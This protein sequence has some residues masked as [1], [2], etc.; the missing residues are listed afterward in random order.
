MKN[1]VFIL[2]WLAMFLICCLAASPQ[3]W[4]KH[5]MP[6][7]KS[8]AQISL[9]SAYLKQQIS[10]IERFKFNLRHDEFLIHHKYLKDFQKHPAQVKHKSHHWV[11]WLV[12]AGAITSGVIYW[13]IQSQNNNAGN[14]CATGTC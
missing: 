12:A 11:W 14:L 5:A 4:A 1:N 8:N 2:K 9:R 3:L 6:L 7:S 10:R 13:I